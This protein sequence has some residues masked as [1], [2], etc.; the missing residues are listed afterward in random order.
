[1]P[2]KRIILFG[3]TG[4]GKSTVGNML[5]NRTPCY[6]RG[7]AVG[8]GFRGVTSEI[9]IKHGNNWAVVDTIGMGETKG[10]T[11][12]HEDAKTFLCTFLKQL[13]YSYLYI[14]YVVRQGRMDESQAMIWQIF[15]KI[16][17]DGESNFVVMFTDSSQKWIDDNETQIKQEFDGCSRFIAVNFPPISESEEL[18]LIYKEKRSL[19]LNNMEEQ[20]RMFNLSPVEPRISSL[21]DKEVPEYVPT[22]LDEIL[23]I[24]QVVAKKC[25]SIGASVVGG[26]VLNV[27]IN[28]LSS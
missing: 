24:G 13:R 6:D 1:M 5:T 25:A 3:R 28:A 26:A 18:E 21:A 8:K 9:T 4:S 11:V 7:F 15:K 14:V 17:K 19:S 22:L 12:S 27:I 10:G 23:R 16:F 20:L 2:D